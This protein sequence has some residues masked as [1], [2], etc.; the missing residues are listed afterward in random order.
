MSS[1]IPHS[2]LPPGAP[3]AP[4]RLGSGTVV[5]FVHGFLDSWRVW[6]AVGAGLRAPEVKSLALDL[7]GCGDRTGHPGPFTLE[8]LAPD[9]ISVLDGIAERR[10]G[11]CTGHQRLPRPR[12]DPHRCRRPSDHHGT[13][14]HR[15]TAALPLRP[16]CR[17]RR[18]G[19]L[20]AP[21]VA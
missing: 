15:R 7:P 8:H 14:R 18:G 11:R 9:V 5:V 10:P 1:S 21:G 12:S 19:P 3:P 6:D 17:R 20:A 2:P 4:E 13:G 16:D